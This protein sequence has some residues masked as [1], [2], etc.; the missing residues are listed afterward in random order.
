MINIIPSSFRTSLGLFH[1]AR[2]YPLIAAIMNLTLSI[3]L[4]KWFGLI[5]VFLA[6]IVVR[7]ICYTIVDTNLIYKNGFM[8][9]S[10]SYYITYVVRFVYMVIMYLCCAYLSLMLGCRDWY[11][12]CV[13]VI[14]YFIIYNILF[15]VIFWNSDT[16]N[17]IKNRIPAFFKK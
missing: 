4:A 12:L 11:I 14:L 15:V 3:F 17:M 5:G 2:F 1:K 9:S 16:F 6:N 10:I 7:I 13:K 8:M